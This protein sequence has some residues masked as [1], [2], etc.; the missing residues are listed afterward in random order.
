MESWRKRWDSCKEKIHRLPDWQSSC[1]NFERAAIVDGG[2]NQRSRKQWFTS[3]RIP[4]YPLRCE[5]SPGPRAA[6]YYLCQE[7]WP[8]KF[9]KHSTLD[10]QKHVILLD[11]RHLDD[12]WDKDWRSYIHFNI[13]FRIGCQCQAHEH[14]G[15]KSYRHFQLIWTT[16]S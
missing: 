1:A 15:Y 14:P 16:S 2:W 12:T 4:G 3:D 9:I 6:S 10:L 13:V 8:F 7:V 11:S 5:A